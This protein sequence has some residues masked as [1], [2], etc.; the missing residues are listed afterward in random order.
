MPIGG[1]GAETEL[2]QG[3]CQLKEACQRGGR[4]FDSLELAVIGL[5]TEEETARNLLEAGFHHLIFSLP[6]A[7]R[8]ESALVMLDSYA[9]LVRRLEQGL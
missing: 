7:N 6:P 1:P 4:L 9:D 3:L 8:R 2:A 5:G